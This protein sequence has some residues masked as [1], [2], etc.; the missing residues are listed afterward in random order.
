MINLFFALAYCNNNTTI[1]EEVEISGSGSVPNGFIDLVAISESKSPAAV[2]VHCCIDKDVVVGSS[3]IAT[4]TTMKTNQSFSAV[5]SDRQAIVELLS[6]S[7]VLLVNNPNLSCCVMI[8]ASRGLCRPYFYLPKLDMLLRTT[9]DI[10][11]DGPDR[12][13][14]LIGNFILSLILNHHFNYIQISKLQENKCGWHDA[15]KSSKMKY[16]PYLKPQRLFTQND[17]RTSQPE[18]P[19][20]K[21]QKVIEYSAFYH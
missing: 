19:N 16:T 11:L 1:Y 9:H 3:S 10:V 12:S 8:K 21:K 5:G 2:A 15:Y 4:A 6:F 17:P 14:K 20:T 18:N 7:Q 13:K